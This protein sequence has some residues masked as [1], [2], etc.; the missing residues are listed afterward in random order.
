[1]LALP[2]LPYQTAWVGHDLLDPALHLLSL[3][4][5][6]SHNL[7]LTGM[8]AWRWGASRYTVTPWVTG[9]WGG[10]SKIP[11]WFGSPPLNQMAFK[12]FHAQRYHLKFSLFFPS[13]RRSP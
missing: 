2:G 3:L 1:M 7:V 11:G 6:H 12:L 10:E 8:D 5:D 4:L 13:G 9:R